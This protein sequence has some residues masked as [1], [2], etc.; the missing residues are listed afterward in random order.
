M[1]GAGRPFAKTADPVMSVAPDR[2][3]DHVGTPRLPPRRSRTCV[4]PADVLDDPPSIQHG[5]RVPQVARV[6][7][8]L[9]LATLALPPE[10]VDHLLELPH[11]L[12]VAILGQWERTG[13]RTLMPLSERL[14]WA[15]L[16]G[17]PLLM[18]RQLV[19]TADQVECWALICVAEQITHLR[20]TEL[21]RRGKSGHA[22]P[23]FTCQLCGLLQE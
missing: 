22:R 23:M 7:V 19:R 20:G 4:L 11:R 18:P 14:S 15:P 10:A 2:V 1:P 13:Q 5:G 17:P 9:R 21:Q 12:H 16:P 6:S 3:G 8:R